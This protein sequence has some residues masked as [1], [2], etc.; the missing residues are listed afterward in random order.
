MEKNYTQEL[1]V[2]LHDKS[3]V[4]IAQI[5]PSVRAAIGEAFGMPVGTNMEA[6]TAAALRRLGFDYVFDTQFSADLTIMEEASEL[7]ERIQGKG[8]L[9]MITSCSAAWM[10]CM[11]QFYPDLIDNVS[12]CK[13]PMSM[14][15][16]L[17][18]TYFAEKMKLDPKKIVSVGVHVLHRQKI[19]GSAAGA[20]CRR[21]ARH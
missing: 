9:P 2:K 14:M 18:K 17:T 10:K 20:Q 4:K 16:A 11:E 19:R 21:Y 15:S 5:A 7:L 6:E 8:K 12:T 3:L 13:S 1:F